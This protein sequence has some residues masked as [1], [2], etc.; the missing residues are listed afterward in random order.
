MPMYE[1]RIALYVRHYERIYSEVEN[2]LGLFGFN[3]QLS[4]I[5]TSGGHATFRINIEKPLPDKALGKLRDISSLDV[6]IK[7]PK[8]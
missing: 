7:N 8:K 5:D 6:L 2:V 3:D 1:F 4:E